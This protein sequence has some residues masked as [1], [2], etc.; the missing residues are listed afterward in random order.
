MRVLVT[1]L[2]SGIKAAQGSTEKAVQAVVCTAFL[3]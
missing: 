1:V 3:F 2:F